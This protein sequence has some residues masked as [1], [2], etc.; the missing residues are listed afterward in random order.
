MRDNAIPPR[1]SASGPYFLDL[2]SLAR[3]RSPT[4]SLHCAWRHR[5]CSWFVIRGTWVVERGSN[6]EQ[7]TT[8]CAVATRSSCAS[9]ATDWC[10]RSRT[11]RSWCWCLQSVS[12]RTIVRTG[13]PSKDCATSSGARRRSSAHEP[14]ITI[15]DP[16]PTIHVP[17]TTGFSQ[18]SNVLARA[19]TSSITYAG[20][21]STKRAPRSLNA[22]TRNCAHVTMPWVA[23]PVPDNGT[24]KPCN[25]SNTPP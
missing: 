5:R 16:R 23:V 3:Q 20:T 13:R 21:R 4:D 8:S 25:R 18:S 6:N 15:H 22:T 10:T 24:A 17:R 12:A 1:T 14:R 19:S 2:E 11:M 9:R 7:R